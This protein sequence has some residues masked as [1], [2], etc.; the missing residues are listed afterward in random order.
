MGA[1]GDL[2]TFITGHCNKVYRGSNRGVQKNRLTYLINEHLQGRKP[3]DLLDKECQEIL[4]NWEAY[5]EC[6]LSGIGR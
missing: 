5:E 1:F 6:A 2:D 4:S 3:Y